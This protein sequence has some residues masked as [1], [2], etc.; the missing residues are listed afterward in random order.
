VAKALSD[1]PALKMT[2]QGAASLEL[3][4]EAF[5]RERLQVMVLAEKRRQMV[6]SGA[7][8]P[9]Q[10]EA[11]LQV[12]A[13]EYPELLTQVYRRSELPKPQDADGKPKVLPLSEMEALLAS[14]IKV[15][16]ESMRELAQ[17]RGVVVRDYLAEKALPPDRLFLGEVKLM[18]A[19]ASWTPRADLMLATP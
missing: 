9:A 5:R 11:P 1:R 16:D 2:V 13:S 14:Y 4:R 19:D 17:R 18:G 8:L 12:A 10:G 6:L 7:A 15:D 3:E